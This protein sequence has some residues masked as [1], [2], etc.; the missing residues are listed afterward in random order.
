MAFSI[1]ADTRTT[2]LLVLALMI[3]F[4]VFWIV[5]ELV[6]L[7]FVQAGFESR[8]PEKKFYRNAELPDLK[9]RLEALA[10]NAA[11]S[12]YYRKPVLFPAD[13]LVMIL[14]AGA[15]GAAS[16]FWLG[17]L[18]GPWAWAGL[19]FPAAYLLFD[20]VEDCLLARMLGDPVS[21]G[22]HV[23]TLVNLTRGKLVTIIISMAQTAVLL[24]LNLIEMCRSAAA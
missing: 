18:C 11:L 15:M 8:F 21:I 20:L 17:R 4:A 6:R 13:L 7:P 23:G 1:S 10:Q 24:V 19:L 14:L 12:S 22:D 3:A 2:L 5:G 9:S 16:Y